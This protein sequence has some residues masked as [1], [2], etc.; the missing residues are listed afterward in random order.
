M[1]KILA[2]GDGWALELAHGH[3]LAFL[4]KAPPELTKQLGHAMRDIATD[5]PA[6]VVK[7]MSDYKAGRRSAASPLMVRTGKLAQ[8]VRGQKLGT[9]IASLRAVIMAGNANVPYAGIQEYGDTI[10]PKNK[11]LRMPLSSILTGAGDVKGEYEIVERANGYQTA[12]GK[13]TWI[14]GRAIM[15]E[16]NGKP[17]PIWALLTQ[18]K[19]PPRLGMGKTIKES[20]EYIRDQLLAAV[21]RTLGRKRRR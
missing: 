12:G 11:Y 10:Y 13:P 17:R 8:S 14:S 16:E 2:K 5:I 9:S 20:G 19:I 3:G 6:E 15:I 21:D 4:G 7:R 18:A 1:A